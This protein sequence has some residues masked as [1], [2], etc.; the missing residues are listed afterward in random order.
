[1]IEGRES[2]RPARRKQINGPEPRDLC[3]GLRIRAP[4]GCR[5]FVFMEQVYNSKRL[6]SAFCHRIHEEFEALFVCNAA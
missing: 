3:L 6:H 5:L 1:M 4:I 2:R